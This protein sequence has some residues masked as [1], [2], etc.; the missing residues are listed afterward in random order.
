MKK[1]IFLTF[2]ILITL[3]SCKT[4]STFQDIQETIHEPVKEPVQETMQPRSPATEIVEAKA[5]EEEK[6]EPTLIKPGTVGQSGGTIFNCNDLNLEMLVVDID[7][8]TYQEALTVAQNYKIIA[9]SKIISS[10][11]L[12]S[13]NELK[14]I[15]EQLYENN[16]AEI[17]ETYYWAMSKEELTAPVLYFGTGFDSEFFQDMDFVGVILVREIFAKDQNENN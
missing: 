7:G 2:I 4:T 14:A 13:K 15:Y 6:E 3:V 5:V 10:W 8:M 1:L 11:R 9:N 17:E 12:P 16:L